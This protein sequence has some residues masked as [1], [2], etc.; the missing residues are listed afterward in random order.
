MGSVF[1]YKGNM[2]PI[3]SP[4]AREVEVTVPAFAR[5][6]EK[7]GADQVLMTLDAFAGEPDLFYHCV[8]YATSHGKSVV[9]G[10]PSQ[11]AL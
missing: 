9:I 3:P 10:A 6:V 11:E 1:W 5:A 7:P 4:I 2:K 8:W